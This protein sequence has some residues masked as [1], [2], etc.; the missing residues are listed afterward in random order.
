MKLLVSLLVFLLLCA[1]LALGIGFAAVNRTL[2]PLDLLIIRFG[3]HSVALWV[4][5][6]FAT[7]GVIGMLTNIGLVLR[8]RTSLL[9]ANRKLRGLEKTQQQEAVDAAVEPATG[10]PTTGE[11]PLLEPVPEDKLAKDR[12]GS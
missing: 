12:T 6:A 1:V 11:P 4:V 10:T 8:L 9:R 7:G 2:V 5:A 3:E